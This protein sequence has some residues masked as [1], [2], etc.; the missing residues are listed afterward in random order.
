MDL[1]ITDVT[2]VQKTN[3]E[4]FTQLIDEIINETFLESVKDKIKYY[5]NTFNYNDEDCLKYS[6]L[7]EFDENLIYTNILKNKFLELNKSSLNS[8]I[9]ADDWCSVDYELT[10]DEE[11]Y[12]I[13][14][15]KEKLK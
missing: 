2:V 14:I 10:S 1:I 9:I 13:N 4:W 3:N 15:I 6:C 7:S 8:N 5:K 11:D 12:I